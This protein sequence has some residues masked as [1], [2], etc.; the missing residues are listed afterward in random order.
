MALLTMD[1]PW[2]VIFHGESITLRCQGPRVQGKQPTAW[3]HNDKLLELTDTDTYRIRNARYK[4]NGR[5]KCQS[6]GSTCSNPI[7]L[8]ISYGQVQDL[9][10]PP[11]GSLADLLILQVPSH[12]VFEG[13]PLHMR[14][15]GWNAL[16]LASV[17]YYRDGADI[18]RPYAS[19]EQ[20][21]IPQ[22]TTHHSGRYHCSAEM[23]SNL[24]LKKR[25]SQ[26]FYVSIRELF[27][28]PVLSVASSA[29]P[30][31]GSPLNLSC[32]TRLSS[33][34][35]HA[36]LWYLFYRNSTVLRGP[37]AS[38]EYQVPTVG[39]ADT[40]SY[41]CEVRTESSSIQKRSPQV[42]ITIR[43]ECVGCW[44]GAAST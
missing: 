10:K 22:A 27:T 19:A 33:Y 7:S 20:L 38:S 26:G 37:I 15:R 44:G 4:Q 24:S 32:I 40:G 23:Y 16:N 36:V 29:E 13:E 43:R 12:A 14:C 31:E 5:Y 30:L 3:Y 9:Q 1:P 42:P 41:S 28:S 17:R 34:R 8:S 6:P 35:P 25:E 11:L 39:L 2:S 18:T 21:L